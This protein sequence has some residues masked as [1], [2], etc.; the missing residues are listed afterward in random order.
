M[1]TSIRIILLF[2]VLFIFACKSTKKTT[3]TIPVDDGKIEVVFL[4]INDVYEIGAL[5]GGKVGGM[6]RVATLR[7]QLLNENANTLTVLAGDFLNPSLIGTMKYEGESIKG[8]QMVEA[9]N[10]TG[11]DLV[12]FGNHEFDLKEPDLQKRINESEFE[13]LGTNV[14]QNRGNQKLPFYQEVEGQRREL[15]RTYIWEVVDEDGTRIKIGLFGATIDSN[16]KDYVTYEDYTREALEAVQELSVEVDVIIGLTHLEIEQDLELAKKVPQVPLLMGGHDHHH[17]KHTVGNTTVAKA[18]ANA[19]SAYVH[20]L[21]YDKKMRR[22][23]VSSRLI[24]IDESLRDDETVRAVVKKWE[25]ILD[26][27]IKEYIDNPSEIIYIAKE[28]LDGRES[29]NRNQQT[30]LGKMI[31]KSMTTAA[32]KPVDCS[33]LNS[34]SIRIDDQ[35]EGNIT[36][37]DIFRTMPYGGPIVEVDMKGSLLLKTLKTGKSKVGNGAYLQYDK[38]YFSPT[39]NEWLIDNKAIDPE[40]V[41]HIMTTDFLLKGL[42]IEFLVADHPDIINIDRPVAS[43]DADQRR[44]IRIAVIN[45][46]KSL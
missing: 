8:K 34:G 16:P 15:P 30:N 45:Y 18:D 1:K 37:V 26:E 36:A 43:D 6:A 13:W 35:L 25:R 20:T 5:E 31:G 22:S 11:V 29:T 7:K 9:M 2:S 19:K 14:L 17:M 32:V 4:Q 46:L 21:Y 38:V 28:P 27:K 10:K 42:D 12:T 23:L 24:T 40:K 41:Y 3:Q 33:F 39:K 44:D